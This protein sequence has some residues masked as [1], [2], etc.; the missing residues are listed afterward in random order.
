MVVITMIINIYQ[1]DLTEKNLGFFSAHEIYINQFFSTKIVT[2]H[3]LI[4]VC[5]LVILSYTYLPSPHSPPP[6][7]SVF[8]STL[9]VSNKYKNKHGR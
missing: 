3:P 5:L 4:H 6:S 9:R 7:S 8:F 2:L 1:N